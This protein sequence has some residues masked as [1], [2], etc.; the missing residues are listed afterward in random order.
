M[1]SRSRKR[2]QRT[3]WDEFECISSPASAAGISLS[4][5]PAGQTTAPSGPGRARARHS[6]KQ[7]KERHAHNVAVA[8]SRALDGLDTSS[9]SIV[10][11]P[12]TPTDATCGPNSGASSATAAL[13]SCLASRLAA[14]MDLSGSPEYE[15][16]W[17][18]SA[19]PLGPPICRL[20]ASAR[21]TS[22][23]GCSGWP[24]PSG[25]DWKISTRHGQ[26]RGQ[27]TEACEGWPTW[28]ECPCCDK[29]LCRLHEL[30][31]H[32]CPCPPIEEWI[33]SPYQRIPHGWATNPV[34]SRWL[35]G[36]PPGWDDCGI[37][38][39]QSSIRSRRNS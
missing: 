2:D 38:A 3:L 12:I 22:D 8:L 10:N 37:M 27:L 23:S 1:R 19:M 16:V 9:V 4:A 17:R 21:R 14:A 32:H 5:P 24:S 7:E 30:H 39:M 25:T 33:V 13:Q 15:L 26:R 31:V 20:R 28:I 36:L 34:L 29:Y 6:R 18:E 35:M 11:T